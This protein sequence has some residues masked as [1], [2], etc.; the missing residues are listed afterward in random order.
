[1]QQEVSHFT[2]VNMNLLL[3]VEDLRMRQSGLVKEKESLQRVINLQDQEKKEFIDDV[4]E[5]L[6]NIEDYKRLK[7]GMVS[8]YKKYVLEEDKNIKKAST[9]SQKGNRDYLEQ[10]VEYLK[11]IMAKTSSE[12]KNVRGRFMKENVM[13]L[14]EINVLK[15]QRHDKLV[16][17]RLVA[18]ANGQTGEPTEQEQRLQELKMQDYMIEDLKHQILQAQ[19][20]N[21][22]FKQRR[23]TT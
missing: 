22:Q 20:A 14:Q 16:E 13:L 9:N 15:K 8:L 18:H 5:T 1:M 19:A 6:L 2:R 3:I 4:Y 17:L 7:K 12:A 23:A 10:K 21:S 11:T